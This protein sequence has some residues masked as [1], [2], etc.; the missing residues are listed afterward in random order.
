[1]NVAELFDLTQWIDREIKGKQIRDRYQNL[2]SILQANAS[3][4]RPQQPFE[5]EKNELIAAISAVPLESLST[6][7]VDFLRK[8]GI[9]GHV[10]EDAVREVE[11]ILFR[12]PLDPATAAQKFAEIIQEIEQGIQKSDQLQNTLTGIIPPEPELEERVLVR[13][14]FSNQATIANVVDLKNWSEVWYDIGRGVAMINDSSPEEVQVVGAGTGSIIIE[15]AVVYGIAKIIAQVILEALKIAEKALDIR[16]KAEDIKALKL[17]NS[18]IAKELEQ[19]A[20]EEKKKGIDLITERVSKSKRKKDVDEG[21]KV[22]AFDRAVSKLVDFLE[23]G[24]QVD[25]VLPEEADGEAEEQAPQADEVK[26]LRKTFKEIRLLEIR[27]AEL[28]D[29]KPSSAAENP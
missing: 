5:N 10:G 4:N 25:C 1:M 14:T 24:G 26:E 27:V 15:L 18:K 13:V 3:G 16:K 28:E 9:G 2:Q 21:D 7:Q 19:A 17:S 8:I 11:D 6:Q 29:K 22:V 20:E 23:R 12:N